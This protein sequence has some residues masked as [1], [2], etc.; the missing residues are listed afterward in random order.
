MLNPRGQELFGGRRTYPRGQQELF[1][2][3]HT[4]YSPPDITVTDHALAELT[5]LANMAIQYYNST[6]GTN[7]TNVKVIE[8]YTASAAGCW[9]YLTFKA[10]LPD[11]DPQ[12]F[13]ASV[14]QGISF[15]APCIE[16]HS[17]GLR[18]QFNWVIKPFNWVQVEALSLSS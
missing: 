8:T 7:Y 9:Y 10:S 14:F 5:T 2:G 17:V 15:P 6:H 3:R 11:D 16:V 13:D 4:Y 1:G 18:K 12:T